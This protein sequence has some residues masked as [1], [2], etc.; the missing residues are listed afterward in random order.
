MR[1]GPGSDPCAD[2]AVAGRGP[3]RPSRRGPRC[4]ART[5]RGAAARAPSGS[6]SRARSPARARRRAAR[7]I[8]ALSLPYQVAAA[9]ALAV[10]GVLACVHLAMVFLH[11][12]PSNTVTKQHG[13][14]VDDWIY[15]EF[16]QNWKLF[17]PNPLQQNIAVQVRAEV[18]HADGGRAT[19]DWI[20]LSAEDGEAIRGNLL[21]SQSSRTS[22]AAPGTSTS[23]RTTTRTARTACAASSPRATCAAS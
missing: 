18:R 6:P 22:C 13:E 8:A 10:V 14:A 11:V 3:E 2:G 15:P 9:L 19:T 1:I 5:D 16:E 4:A 21:P 12:A 17:A 23:T 7:G 20:D